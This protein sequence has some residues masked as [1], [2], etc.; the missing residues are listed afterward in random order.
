MQ[1]FFPAFLTHDRLRAEIAFDAP[2]IFLNT[3]SDTRYS[4]NSKITREV[5]FLSTHRTFSE[6]KIKF[7]FK[8]SLYW[9]MSLFLFFSLF[10]FVVLFF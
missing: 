7:R 10:S 4:E 6:R 1:L 3:T 8:C 9:L 2:F 5:G